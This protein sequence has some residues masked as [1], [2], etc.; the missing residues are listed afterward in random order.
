VITNGREEML[1]E[2]GEKMRVVVVVVDYVV[3]EMKAELYREL[4]DMMGRT[5]SW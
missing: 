3:K 5:S 4:M 1:M 2:G